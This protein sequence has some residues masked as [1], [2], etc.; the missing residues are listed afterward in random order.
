MDSVA[1]PS[2]QIVCSPD[3]V[4]FFFKTGL[5]TSVQPNLPY[6]NTDIHVDLPDGFK[7]VNIIYTE[8]IDTTKVPSVNINSANPDDLIFSFNGFMLNPYSTL[9]ELKLVVEPSCGSNASKASSFVT[10]GGSTV[11]VSDTIATTLIQVD[12]PYLVFQGLSNTTVANSTINLSR[13]AIGQKFMRC[14]KSMTTSYFSARHII[15]PISSFD[16]ERYLISIF[17]KT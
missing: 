14:F 6:S 17:K 7:Y 5:D 2:P 1:F 3:T 11:V 4:S 12:E 15:N 16:I 13:L 10:K 8:S 9:F